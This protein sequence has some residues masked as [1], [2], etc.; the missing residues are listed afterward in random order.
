[1]NHPWVA[2]RKELLH[3]HSQFFVAWLSP[4]AE[5]E[6]QRNDWFLRSSIIS[7]YSNRSCVKQ[8]F[9][10]PITDIARQRRW[11]RHKTHCDSSYCQWKRLGRRDGLNNHYRKLEV[12]R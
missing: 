8:W 10:P 12:N 7:R 11:R 6:A 4:F 5:L 9:Q 2:E 3:E 1:M